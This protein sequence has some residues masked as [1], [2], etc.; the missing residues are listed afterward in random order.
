MNRRLKASLAVGLAALL[1]HVYGKLA[2]RRWAH[3]YGMDSVNFDAWVSAVSIGL[4]FALV[5]FATMWITLRMR[6]AEPKKILTLFVVA[7]ALFVVVRKSATALTI[8]LWDA[9]VG[10][11]WETDSLATAWVVTSTALLAIASIVLSIIFS[12]TLGANS[13]PNKLLERTR[14]E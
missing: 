11:L 4:L 10:G 1:L 14:E 9:K 13:P 8:Y 7:V 3:K 12:L 5:T 6:R 2:A